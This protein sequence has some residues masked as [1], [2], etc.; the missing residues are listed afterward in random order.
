[1]ANIPN[2]NVPR[3][4]IDDQQ[5]LETLDPFLQ[6]QKQKRVG[7]SLTHQISIKCVY[8]LDPVIVISKR[9]FFSFITTYVKGL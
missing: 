3:V 1:M 2:V 4:L 6:K 5:E 9:L 7:Y 8:V